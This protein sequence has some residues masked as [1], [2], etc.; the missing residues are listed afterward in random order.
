MTRHT[1]AEHLMI[2]LAVCGAIAIF[3]LIG[4]R[5]VPAGSLG[6][7]F[8]VGGVTAALFTVLVVTVVVI[9]L[10]LVFALRSRR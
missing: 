8:S 6:I 7:S 2:V 3:S 9:G 10:A 4:A 5:L 1:L